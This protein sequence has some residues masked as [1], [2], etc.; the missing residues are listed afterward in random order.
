M[1]Q[2]TYI[3]PSIFLSILFIGCGGSSS[4]SSTSLDTVTGR[5]IDGPVAGLTYECSSGRQGE[6]NLNGKF[7][8][9]Q[10]DQVTFKV[11]AVTLGTTDVNSTITPYTLYP[12]NQEVAINVAQ[13]LQTLDDDGNLTTFIID[14]TKVQKLQ[15][16]LDIKMPADQF[17]VALASVLQVTPVDRI[18]AIEHMQ[19]SI[20]EHLLFTDSHPDSSQ[21]VE[22]EPPVSIPTVNG[23]DQVVTPPSQESSI[24][25]SASSDP[26]MPT[27]L[28]SSVSNQAT[29]VPSVSGTTSETVVKESTVEPSM[30]CQTGPAIQEGRVVDH[31]T[32]EPLANVEVTI[33][34][35]RVITDAQGFY[36]LRDIAV[37]ERAVVTL[38]HEGYYRHS[39][40][41]QVKEYSTGKTTLSPN[42]LEYALDAYDVNEYL[43][44]DTNHIVT[45]ASGAKI[46]LPANIYQ[47][48]NGDLYEGN[49][50]VYSAFEDPATEEGKK[51]FPGLFE[52]KNL[53]GDIL[54][55]RAYGLMVVDLQDLNGEPVT[56]ADRIALI[57]PAVS[58]LTA[59]SIPLWYYDYTEG[60]WI[61][62]GV[63]VRQD[64]GTYRGLVSHAGTW[65][66]S[67]PVTEALGIYRGRIIYRNGNPVKDARVYA[68]G[69]NWVRMDVTTDEN[70]IFEL[71]VI[72]GEDF[73]IY[74][75][76]YKWKYGA[77]YN[78]T[79]SG[80]ASGEI[81][82]D[83]L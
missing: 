65:C 80:V 83:R 45:I 82:E 15:E 52:G 33:G 16:N 34:G 10:G 81:V 37:N 39:T 73:T 77:D 56:L 74:A 75:Y 36:T 71:E 44:S 41:I 1:K 72:P 5:F 11:G 3:L 78:G 59:E 42:Y 19:R 27:P 40:I 51:V 21:I 48:V 63:A 29:V 58:G 35:C 60:I 76:N 30:R 64:D 55:F 6:T 13:L 25:T 79:I 50:S 18:S 9:P 26:I 12:D 20:A 67:Q 28:V 17:E 8:C 31:Q 14:H 69:S 22:T 68:I 54:P 23:A 7:T 32:G 53:N 70:G 57:F 62:E 24:A 61:E 4:S 2:L 38:T 49:I 47:R 43:Q 66:L 46:E